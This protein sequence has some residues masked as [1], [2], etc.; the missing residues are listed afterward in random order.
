MSTLTREYAGSPYRQPATTSFNLN[1]YPTMGSG[2]FGFV[3]GQLGLPSPAS[4]LGAVYPGLQNQNKQIGNT[5]SAQLGGKL[6]PE[7]QMAL[8]D[9]TSSWGA[10]NGMPGSNALPGTIANYRGARDL[11]LATEK[12]QQQ[13]IQNYGSII[14]TISQTQTVTPALQAEI[15]NINAIN[16]AAPNPQAR[17]DYLQ[18]LF[19][20]TVS[21]MRGPMGDFSLGMQNVFGGLG[22]LGGLVGGFM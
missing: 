12:L 4:D 5:I 13:G 3:P 9:Y 1:P 19:K 10:S 18:D 22:S 7:T 21:Y 20:D 17:A 15:A 14:P 11:G 6:S 8:Q 16:A 2:A